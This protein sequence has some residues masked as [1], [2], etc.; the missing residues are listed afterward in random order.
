LKNLIPWLWGGVH[1][2]WDGVYTLLNFSSMTHD[3]LIEDR[4]NGGIYVTLN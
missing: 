1:T 2:L 4:G 3:V